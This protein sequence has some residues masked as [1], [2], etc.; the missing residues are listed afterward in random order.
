MY[1]HWDP[2]KQQ[3]SV[4]KQ[5]HSLPTLFWNMPFLQGRLPL[6]K[7]AYDYLLINIWLPPYKHHYS[8]YCADGGCFQTDVRHCHSQ[9][10]FAAYLI[11]WLISKS[12]FFSPLFAAWFCMTALVDRLQHT[13]RRIS[14]FSAPSFRKW[15]LAMLPMVRAKW[16]QLPLS[17]YWAAGSKKIVGEWLMTCHWRMETRPNLMSG[18]QA[19]FS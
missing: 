5:Q 17:L 15:A 18:L 12:V 16:A 4:S 3:Y 9:G 10:Q 1:F 14:Q 19:F 6:M 13:G 7:I 11:E 2:L 8:W